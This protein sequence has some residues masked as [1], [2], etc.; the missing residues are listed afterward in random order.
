VVNDSAV[1]DV[2]PIYSLTEDS[3]LVRAV[4][5]N[6]TNRSNFQIQVFFTQPAGAISVAPTL[7]LPAGNTVVDGHRSKIFD[8]L[9]SM[10]SLMAF[11][12]TTWGTKAFNIQFRSRLNPPP[13]YTTVVNVY[14]AMTGCASLSSPDSCMRLPGCIYCF[15]SENWRILRERLPENVSL[16]EAKK[17]RRL[18]IEFMPE[19]VSDSGQDLVGICGDGWLNGDCNT[20]APYGFVSEANYKIVQPSI[21]LVALA[22]ISICIVS[23]LS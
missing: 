9:T 15:T 5:V 7:T 18:F 21:T 16:S 13:V 10:K 11:S 17:A 14:P 1:N 3:G 12:N 23:F 8:V 6:V 22:V 2:Y 4:Q 19:S 20:I